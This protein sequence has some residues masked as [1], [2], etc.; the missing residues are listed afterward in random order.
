M[1]IKTTGTRNS[2]HWKRYAWRALM[3]YNAVM[4]LALVAIVVDPASSHWI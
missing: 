3:A 2:H 1:D 4:S